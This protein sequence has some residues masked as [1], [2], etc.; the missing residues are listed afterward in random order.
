M[1]SEIRCILELC[2]F[3]DSDKET[4]SALLAQP[5][6]LPYILGQVL[7]NRMG[8]AAYVTLKENNLL[9]RVNREFRSTLQA[10]YQVGVDKVR[11][12]LQALEMLE[13]VLRQADFPYA[14]LKGA[15]LA[16][17]Y[18]MGLRTSNDIDILIEHQHITSLAQLLSQAGFRQGNI[19]SGVFTAA[20]RAEIIS[21]RMNRGETIP[22]IKKIDLPKMEYLELDINFSLDF[23]AKNKNDNVS[24]LLQ[25]AEMGINGRL[26]TLSLPDFLIHLCAHL[27]K[28][29]TVI[30]WVEMGRDQSLYKYADIYLFVH[31][32]MTPAFAKLLAERITA[33]GL[34]KECAYAFLYTREL[35][36]IQNENF[37]WLIET[38]CPAD[39]NFRRQILEPQTGK[40]YTHA[41]NLTEWIFCM[42]R[43]EHLHETGY[44]G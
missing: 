38:I 15:F 14:L 20:T 5:L 24:I 11:S 26:Y 30:S 39:T 29:A 33:Y 10:I 8:G 42:N 12:L 28:E 41:L 31:R 7:Y 37:D 25:R 17:L 27:Y 23:Q 36:F 6:D 35:F 44:D 34:Q 22:F 16:G 18:P 4:L 9:G 19:R 43:K 40:L 13:D 2:R 32:Y 21:S 1:R 3:L